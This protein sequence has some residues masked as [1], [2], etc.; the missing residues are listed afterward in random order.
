MCQM[1]GGSNLTSLSKESRNSGNVLNDFPEEWGGS[2]VFFEEQQAECLY[3]ILYN[4]H[5]LSIYYCTIQSGN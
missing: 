5:G 2:Y 4:I 1:V 3:Y